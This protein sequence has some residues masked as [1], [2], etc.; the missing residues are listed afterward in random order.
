MTPYSQIDPRWGG[1]KIGPS[2]TTIH[3][4]GCALTALCNGAN[5]ILG[6]DW[7]PPQIAHNANLFVAEKDGTVDILNWDKAAA[8]IGKI[9]HDGNDEFEN[10]A[11]ID[12]YLKDPNK[13][14][15]LHVNNNLHFVLAWKKNILGRYMCLDSWDGKVK[16]VKNHYKNIKGARYFSKI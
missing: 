16:D 14:V 13:F 12:L 7:K 2:I 8:F 6:T 5:A 11:K 9:K 10:D 4:A 3:M 1:D 15:I